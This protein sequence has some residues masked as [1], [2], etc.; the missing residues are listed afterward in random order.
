MPTSDG[1]ASGD[2]STRCPSNTV[3][4]RSSVIRRTRIATAINQHSAQTA[5]AATPVPRTASMRDAPRAP[6]QERRR[7]GPLNA[8]RTM[9]RRR[10]AC[11]SRCG[12]SASG[13]TGSALSFLAI[14]TMVSPVGARPGSA[15]ASRHSAAPESPS[16]A[17]NAA[18]HTNR[19][20][21]PTA[22]QTKSAGI[23]LANRR[24]ETNTVYS[25]HA[26]IMSDPS[27]ARTSFR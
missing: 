24:R 6:S 16:D 10:A 18:H 22:R 19:V 11:G 25:I 9:A 17:S 2:T 3:S 12:T 27:G 20:G 15:N 5:A 1:P 4:S 23:A 26:A 14:E 13:A 21:R 8:A 7:S